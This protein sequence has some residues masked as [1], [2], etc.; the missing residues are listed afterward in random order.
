MISKKVPDEL[1]ALD[2]NGEF[3]FQSGGLRRITRVGSKGFI[4]TPSTHII[5]HYL[6]SLR[7]TRS[8]DWTQRS[9]GYN[10]CK[11]FTVKRLCFILK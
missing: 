6:C 2:A 10:H 7:P 11:C 5:E 1:S 8:R 9:P 4:L 3:L